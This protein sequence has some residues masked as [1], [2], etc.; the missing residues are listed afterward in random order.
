MF[1]SSEP[2]DFILMTK[3]DKIKEIIQSLVIECHIWHCPHPV[4]QIDLTKFDVMFEIN[5]NLRAYL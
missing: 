5:A 4:S 1:I 2:L 3:F